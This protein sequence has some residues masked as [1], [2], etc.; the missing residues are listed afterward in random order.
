MVRKTDCATG[1]EAALQK[2]A[3]I[4]DVRF[5]YHDEAKPAPRWQ[6]PVSQLLT[7][8]VRSNSAAKYYH[9]T[10]LIPCL[11][12]R[13][14]IVLWAVLSHVPFGGWHEWWV[15][16][17]SERSIVTDGPVRW[18]NRA[19]KAVWPHWGGSCPPP[20]KSAVHSRYTCLRM[21]SGM[22][23]SVV[24]SITCSQWLAADEPTQKAEKKSASSC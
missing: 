6:Q 21:Y 17:H 24:S 10:C 1:Y 12:Y 18:W 20:N 13:R 19:T 8:S 4:I 15:E 7:Q 3:S 14:M 9:K 11:S 5:I 16:P 2:Y 23:D 22:Y